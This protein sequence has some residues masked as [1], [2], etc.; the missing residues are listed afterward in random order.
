MIPIRSPVV[1]KLIKD[2]LLGLPSVLNIIVIVHAFPVNKFHIPIFMRLGIRSHDCPPRVV[3]RVEDPVR[4]GKGR[5]RCGQCEYPSV[6]LDRGRC[7]TLL[8][9]ELVQAFWGLVAADG[10]KNGSNTLLEDLLGVFC[11]VGTKVDYSCNAEDC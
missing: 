1:I 5:V 10:G 7:A 6:D 2:R 4:H 9:V 11:R 8:V 3:Y